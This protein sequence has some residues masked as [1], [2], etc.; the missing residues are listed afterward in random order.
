MSYFT[1]IVFVGMM[2]MGAISMKDLHV[3][4]ISTVDYLA[5]GLVPIGRSLLT[6]VLLCVIPLLTRFIPLSFDTTILP[7]YIMQLYSSHHKKMFTTYQCKARLQKKRK[8]R[9]NERPS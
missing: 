5:I 2:L 9:N 8:F 7:K 6:L 4:L 1:S 3:L